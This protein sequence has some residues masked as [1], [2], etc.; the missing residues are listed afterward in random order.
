MTRNLSLALLCVTFAWSVGGCADPTENMV[1]VPAAAPK[2]TTDTPAPSPAENTAATII[3][4]AT[5]SAAASAPAGALPIALDGSKVD[6]VGSKVTGKHV[7]GFKTFS[8]FTE[9]APDGKALAKINLEIAMD[10]TWSDNEKLTGH[11][12]APDFFDVAKYPKS[13]FTSTEIK[14]GGE[15]GATH[16]ITGNLTL[17]GVTKSISIPA[18]IDVKDGGVTIS[19]E[20]ALNRKDFGIAYTGMTNDLIR[21]EVG[22][23]MVVKAPKKA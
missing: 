2:P 20:F 18:T 3:P 13:T 17:H 10:S 15:K 23:K 19:S 16:T 7:G 11:L 12:K 1:K 6:F 9:L 8:G 21:D 4:S 22:I 5:P 14:A